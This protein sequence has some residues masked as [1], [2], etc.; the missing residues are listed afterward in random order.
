MHLETN[1]PQCPN[2]NIQNLFTQN[3]DNQKNNDYMEQ[4]YL[5][6][7]YKTQNSI[8]SDFFFWIEKYAF[9]CFICGTY[10]FHSM[11]NIIKINIDKVRAKRDKEIPSKIGTNLDLY[12]I[13]NYYFSKKS[14]CK[15]CQHQGK[16]DIKILVNTKILIIYFDRE[17]HTN[18]FKGDINFDTNINL[19]EYASENKSKDDDIR[20]MKYSLKS[21]ICFNGVKYFSYC[22]INFTKDKNNEV[23]Y[24][25]MDNEVVKVRGIN[26]LYNWEPQILIYEQQIE[27]KENSMNYNQASTKVYIDFDQGKFDN[28]GNNNGNNNFNNQFNKDLYMNNN[29][30]SNNTNNNNNDYN[31]YNYNNNNYNNNNYNN[32][33]NNNNFNNYK[34]NN[35]NNNLINCN[36]NIYNNNNCH[37]CNNE[38]FNNVFNNNNCNNNC[39]NNNQINGNS[40][41]SKINNTQNTINSLNSFPTQFNITN[42]NFIDSLDKSILSMF[43]NLTDSHNSLFDEND[44]N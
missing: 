19:K 27:S 39:N 35:Y 34:N 20:I 32:N 9:N 25:F 7:F 3:I 38:N 33:F 24:R 17:N 23:L 14:K 21:C 1:L 4:L 16:E 10:Y 43:D 40:D 37:N 13:L 8:I 18:N 41:F 30:N 26:E 5:D 36:N 22:Y 15:F 6:F 29:I 44:D 2:Y 42:Q 12:Y 28:N 11:K 31:N